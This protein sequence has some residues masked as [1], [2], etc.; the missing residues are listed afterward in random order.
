MFFTFLNLFLVLFIILTNN[1]NIHLLS[2]ILGL[3]FGVGI[4][5]SVILNMYY[6]D[7]SKKYKVTGKLLVLMDIITH[8]LPMIYMYN[9]TKGMDIKNIH[10]HI[11]TSYLLAY[12]Y[13]RIFNYNVVYPGV[14]EYV[15]YIV[16]PL[17]VIVPYII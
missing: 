13:S 8:I 14:P 4:T 16:Y 9:R 17:A 12:I 6:T 1:K 15:F 3:T 10:L 2:T 5:G 11:L 7:F